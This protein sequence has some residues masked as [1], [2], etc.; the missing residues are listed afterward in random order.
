M[1]RLGDVVASSGQTLYEDVSDI[2][3][4]L[5]GHLVDLIQGVDR[6]S[7][8]ESEEALHEIEDWVL[9]LRNELN[10][11]VSQ[12]APQSAAAQRSSAST[13]NEFLELVPLLLRDVISTRLK[14][15]EKSDPKT[16]SPTRE[17]EPPR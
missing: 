12:L 5:R 9:Q 15:S 13:T 8:E 4:C 17:K 10:R 7:V 3:E 1:T 11:A 14:A 16:D 2:V 6:G